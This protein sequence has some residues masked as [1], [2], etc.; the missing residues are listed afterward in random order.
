MSDQRERLFQAATV[1]NSGHFTFG[2]WLLFFGI[3]GIWGSSFLLIAYAL[4]DFTPG[5]IT[6]G[7]VALGAL[8]LGAVRAARPR[9]PSVDRT[10][11]SRFILVSVLWVGIPFT[12]FPL[13]QER[14]NSAI[15]GLLNGAVP[16]F[17]ALV[18]TVL[19][20]SAP[21]GTQLAGIVIG[22]VGITMVSLAS[23]GGES[24]EAIGVI[25]V[26]AATV[27]Y[28]FAINLAGPL[29]QKYGAMG[30]MSRVLALATIWVTPFGLWNVAENGFSARS[31][32]AVIFLGAVGTGAAYWIMSTLVGRVGGVRASFITYLIPIVSLILGVVFRDDVVTV[33][34]VIGATVT[35]GGALLASRRDGAQR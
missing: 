8:T 19:L 5:M 30:T 18:A 23:A 15:T 25:M 14:I 33:I 16:I 4:E 34:A 10:D 9:G 12:L 32:A 24:S 28:G 13:A 1:D 21:R 29:Q 20:K 35:I 7:R 17:V 11:W 26:L 22:F 27:C 2:D 3:A 31:V 6:L